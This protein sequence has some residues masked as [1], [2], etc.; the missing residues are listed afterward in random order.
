MYPLFR[1]IGVTAFALLASSPLAVH[2]WRVRTLSHKLFLLIRVF[3]FVLIC[4]S[5]SAFAFEAFGF[6]SG[7]SEASAEKSASN[8]GRVK[9]YGKSLTVQ[10]QDHPDHGYLFNFCEGR[11]YEAGQTFP[12]NFDQMANFIDATIQEYGQPFSVST[13]GGMGGQ[14]FVRPINLYWT[15]GTKDYLR[16]CNFKPPTQ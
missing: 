2:D 14:G 11:L 6:V 10:A 7:M 13:Q 15:V 4:N 8:L 3:S 5:S 9:W 12:S 16:V 1:T